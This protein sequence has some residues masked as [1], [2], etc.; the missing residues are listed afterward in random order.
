M[1]TKTDKAFH[2]C[3]RRRDVLRTYIASR[4]HNWDEAEDLTHDVFEKLWKKRESILPEAMEAWVYRT[5]RNLVIDVVRT[6]MVRE[7]AAAGYCDMSETSP[8]T[9]ERDLAFQELRDL[10]TRLI[11]VLPPKRRAV[12]CLSFFEGRDTVHI[13][14]AMSVAASTVERQLLTARKTIRTA[15]AESYQKYG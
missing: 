6:R 8:E 9:P 15:L 11:N 3:Y 1:E 12:Y 13:A 2:E 10:H 14:R 4:T 7:K 5:A